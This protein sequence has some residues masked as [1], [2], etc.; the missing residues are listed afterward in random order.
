MVFEEEVR[1]TVLGSLCGVGVD[2]AIASLCRLAISRG[3]SLTER[4][5]GGPRKAD[6]SSSES[7]STTG[8]VLRPYLVTDCGEDEA[9][10]LAVLLASC[11]CVGV[12]R[13]LWKPES[14][15]PRLPWFSQ[16]A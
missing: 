7:A 13:E 1:D 10:E 16:S 8:G 2:D 6:S 9:E 14:G 15:L 5:N 12:A 4:R 11:D 3:D